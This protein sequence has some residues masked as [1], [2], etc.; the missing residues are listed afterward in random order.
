MFEVHCVQ[1]VW[2]AK[3]DHSDAFFNGICNI[4]PNVT[5]VTCYVH[6]KRNVQKNKDRK[7]GAGFTSPRL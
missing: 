4:C 2:V 5:M 7:I 1:F 3:C 6:L